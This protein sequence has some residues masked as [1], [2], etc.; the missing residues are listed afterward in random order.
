MRSHDQRNLGS[1]L[2]TLEL[3]TLQVCEL[4]GAVPCPH[5]D[6]KGDPTSPRAERG[7]V[8]TRRG[9]YLPSAFP[10]SFSIRRAIGVQ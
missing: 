10:A 6:R 2:V 8:K 3:S 1:H 5:P 4:A 7:E 9:N